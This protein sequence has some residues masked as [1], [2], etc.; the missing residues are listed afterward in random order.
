V[1]WAYNGALLRSVYAVPPLALL[2]IV[3][4]SFRADSRSAGGVYEAFTEEKGLSLAECVADYDLYALEVRGLAASTREMHRRLLR[5]VGRALPPIFA[6]FHTMPVWVFDSS[7]ATFLSRCG[8][9]I[10]R[11]SRSTSSSVQ[12]WLE[13]LLTGS[14]IP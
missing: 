5:N 12:V 10:S 2:S 11:R 13:A 1:K 4:D 8:A 6:R 9:C 14:G 3:V 7:R